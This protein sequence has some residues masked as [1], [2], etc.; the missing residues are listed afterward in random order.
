LLP[1]IDTVDRTS[2]DDIDRL[3][4]EARDVIAAAL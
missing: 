4:A 1:P 3:I 2:D